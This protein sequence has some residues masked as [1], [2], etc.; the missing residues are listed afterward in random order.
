MCL[1]DKNPDW[2]RA[3]KTADRA[4]LQARISLN[5]LHALS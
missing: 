4:V 5:T 2:L 1:D 3:C